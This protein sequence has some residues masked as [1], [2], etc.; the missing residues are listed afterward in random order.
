MYS[1]LTEFDGS[2]KQIATSIFGPWPIQENYFPLREVSLNS[3]LG[4]GGGGVE[5]LENS[6]M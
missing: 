5:G 6:H 3:T 4:L 2:T 1:N